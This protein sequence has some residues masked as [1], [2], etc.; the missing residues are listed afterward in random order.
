M[1]LRLLSEQKV[2]RVVI[3]DYDPA[4]YSFWHNAVNRSDDFAKA[5]F[6]IEP[7][8]EE[9][10][11]QKKVLAHSSSS[12]ERG[13][14][15]LF[16]NRTNRSGVINGGVIGGLSQE[17]NYKIDARY[18]KKTLADK[19]SFLKKNASKITVRNEDGGELIR[20]YSCREDAFF[21]VDPPYVEKGK[22]LYLNALAESDHRALSDVLH[23]MRN[24][25]WV[26]TYDDATL[27]KELY[28]D[29]FGGRF[30]LSYSALSRRRAEELM[31][32]SDCL[33]PL[34]ER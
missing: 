5:F 20:E 19:L 27:V 2:S 28:S 14:A 10:H 33:W 26:L 25:R 15:F 9:W 22:S 8:I 21:Y 18:N 7:T 1:S 31:F 29:C 12:L 24:S 16:L 3:N 4:V 30:S 34:M 11:R 17:G 32:F 6:S 13:V 23:G